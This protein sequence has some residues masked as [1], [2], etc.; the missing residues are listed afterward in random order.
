[1]QKQD[2]FLDKHNYIK[3]PIQDCIKIWKK[4]F[5]V[6]VSQDY[7][8]NY[9]YARLIGNNKYVTIFLMYMEIIFLEKKNLMLQKVKLLFEDP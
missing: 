9:E 2:I 3:Y 8:T 4:Q 1:M 6:E 5:N 7:I